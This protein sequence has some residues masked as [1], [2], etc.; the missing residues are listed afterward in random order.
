MN[1]LFIFGYGYTANYLLKII[2]LDFN[3]IIT[4]N[5]STT[6][7]NN[8]RLQRLLDI[9]YINLDIDI[10]SNDLNVVTNNSFNNSKKNFEI[11]I[12]NHFKESHFHANTL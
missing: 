2:D 11:F 4:S 8:I 10:F 3:N 9:K 5:K 1:N 7:S 12:R 6:D